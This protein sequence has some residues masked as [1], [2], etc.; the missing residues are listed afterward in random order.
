MK[1]CEIEWEVKPGE[2]LLEWSGKLLD[3]Q[4]GE[5]VWIK[6]PHITHMGAVFQKDSTEVRIIILMED[7]DDTDGRKIADT[8]IHRSRSESS[9]R[10]RDD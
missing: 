4:L 5:M 8:S 10:A 7:Q 9:T 6:D 1:L 2:I 3:A